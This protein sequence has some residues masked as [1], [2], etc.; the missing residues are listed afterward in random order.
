MQKIEKNPK[1]GNYYQRI[2]PIAPFYPPYI[3]HYVS[4]GIEYL[5]R[6]CGHSFSVLVLKP[7]F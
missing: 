7:I 5:M 4:A 1:K 3:R 6:F 2:F